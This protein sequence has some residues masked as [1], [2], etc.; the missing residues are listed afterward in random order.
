M[1]GLSAATTYVIITFVGGLPFFIAAV[2]LAFLYYSGTSRLKCTY[3]G[4]SRLPTVSK[5]YGQTSRD[6]RRLG[7]ISRIS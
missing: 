1:Y 4:H 2:I 5:V 3:P 6:M 7:R